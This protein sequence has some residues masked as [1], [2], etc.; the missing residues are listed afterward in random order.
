MSTIKPSDNAKA[1][2]T[3][4]DKEKGKM[5]NALSEAIVKEKPNVQWDDIAGL[6]AA[7][8]GLQEAV[9]LPIKFP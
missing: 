8:Q 2:K 6:K 1:V 9:I 4:E 5:Q 3:E 7:K